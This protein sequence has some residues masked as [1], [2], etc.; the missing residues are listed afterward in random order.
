MAEN[1]TKKTTKTAVKAT[2]TTQKVTEAKLHRR[3][4]TGVVVSD[5][6]MKT[7]VVKVERRV[8]DTVYGKYIVK[9]NKFKVHDE[10]NRAKAGDLVT[11]VESRPLSKEKRW[12]LQSIVRS[13]SGEVLV[14]G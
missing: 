7:C 11:I 1:K 14:K 5:K 9:A 8:R 12:A 13:A 3:T 6:M 4:M 2:E 10:T